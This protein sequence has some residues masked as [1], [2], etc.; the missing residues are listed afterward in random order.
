MKEAFEC[1]KRATICETLAGQAREAS[2][3]RALRDLAEQW[4]R[5]AND[6][7]RYERLAPKWGGESVKTK[8]P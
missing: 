4:R 1:L 6:A 7:A 3:T 2:S 5:M 8:Q